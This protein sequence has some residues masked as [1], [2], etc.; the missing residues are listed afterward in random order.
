MDCAE[1]NVADDSEEQSLFVINTPQL[2]K[3]FKP[4]IN[5]NE[6]NTQTDP[7]KRKLYK[8]TSHVAEIKVIKEEVIKHVPQEPSAPR[9]SETFTNRLFILQE[10]YDKIS[11]FSYY[12][13][14][15]Y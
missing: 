14:K 7:L 13:E 11:K 9:I 12:S 15:N 3:P 6:K 5:R 1:E 10:F 2:L 4:A 8:M